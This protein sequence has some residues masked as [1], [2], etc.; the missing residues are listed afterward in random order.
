MQYN[1]N[2]STVS[3]DAMISEFEACSH[4]ISGSTSLKSL[5][6]SVVRSLRLDRHYPVDLNLQEAEI[7][8][9]LLRTQCLCKHSSEH[10]W[11]M[12]TNLACNGPSLD[13]Y[14]NSCRNDYWLLAYS[15]F[16]A[17]NDQDASGGWHSYTQIKFSLR[18][19]DLQVT[20][21]QV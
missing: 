6:K 14:T 13:G 10:V 20:A 8:H 15:R 9:A 5:P 21:L 3:S 16:F 18:Q 4:Y 1:C 19:S 7:S 2:T 11:E 12:N 17:L